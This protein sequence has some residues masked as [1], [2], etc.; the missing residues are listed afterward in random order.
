MQVS[1][2][3]EGAAEI[4]TLSGTLD[5]SVAPEVRDQLK[6]IVA[7]G[8]VRLVLDLANVNFI[9]SSGLSAL[10][11]AF[12]AARAAGGD[13]ALANLTPAV[14]SIVELTRLHRIMDVYETEVAAVGR[15]G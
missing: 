4:V 15:L 8:R 9:D 10:V 14:R 5:A 13:V 2:R 6:R 3:A 7:E 11:T 12:K 1:R